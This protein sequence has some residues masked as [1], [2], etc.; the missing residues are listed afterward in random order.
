MKRIPI[1]VA[2]A[3]AIS[4]FALGL[5]MQHPAP[6]NK[7][8]TAAHSDEDWGYEGSKLPPDKW[9][10]RYPDC[11]KTTQS[12]IRIIN[13]VRKALPAIVFEYQQT[14]VKVVCE[15]HG[16]KVNYDPGSSIKLKDKTYHLK[17]FHFHL[18]SEHRVGNKS[19]AVEM[20]LVHE[21][22]SGERAVIGV[23]IEKNPNSP[24]NPAYKPIVDSLPKCP[25]PYT[26]PVPVVNAI[27]LLPKMRSYYTYDGSLTTPPCTPC[28]QWFVLTTPVEL[29]PQQVDAFFSAQGSKTNNRPVQDLNNRKVEQSSS[30]D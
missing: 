29:S 11:G 13:P 6:G 24:D 16:L 20:H 28:V 27:D 12:P 22:D 21:T 2:L 5:T 18:P 19:F 25:E 14:N 1:I 23:L 30:R 7:S 9:A 8:G 26:G 10:T 17:Q 3:L 15:H 4:S